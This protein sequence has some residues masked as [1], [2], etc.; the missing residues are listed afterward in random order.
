MENVQNQMEQK[1]LNIYEKMLAI[2]NEL[3]SVAKNLS[4]GVG[5]GQYKA[6]GEAD[7]LAAVKPL[8]EKYKIYS[9]PHSRKVIF[10][11]EKATKN[12]TNLVLRVE[13]IYRFVNVENPN[14]FIDQ[15]S[16]GDG[17]DSQD[18]APG[19]AMT[20]SD[21]YALMKGYKI[22]TGDDP[23]QYSSEQQSQSYNS[24]NNQ[25]QGQYGNN[26]QSNNHRQPYQQPQQQANYYPNSQPQVQNQPNYAIPNPYPS[27][28]Q[29]QAVQGQNG[30]GNVG[31]KM[32]SEQWA[33]V[34]NLEQKWINF[35][36]DKLKLQ[37]IGQ[38][39]KRQADQVLEA[40]KKRGVW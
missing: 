36:C 35:I 33:I 25:Q 6:V 11:G 37:N 34:S 20:Y 4:I 40:L 12:G 5:A 32:T 23:D 18:K 8:E 15:I 14:E 16:Y 27:N 26:Y 19:K 1:P 28:N 22:I 10:V 7:I 29:G 9:Y 24:Q 13:T 2:T 38:M 39:T 17:I 30:Q 3:T 31:E 21:K